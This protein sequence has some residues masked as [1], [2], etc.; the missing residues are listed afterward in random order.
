MIE[1]SCWEVAIKQAAEDL[2]AMKL[3]VFD[4]VLKNKTVERRGLDLMGKKGGKKGN[5][6]GK[7]KDQNKQK[8]QAQD[9]KGKKNK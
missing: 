7:Q 5:K 8:Q 6:G 1:L 3:V 9:K 4:S 2:K